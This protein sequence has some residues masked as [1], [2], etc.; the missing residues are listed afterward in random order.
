MPRFADMAARLG[1]DTVRLPRFSIAWMMAIVVVVAIDFAVC[2]AL[3][4][5]R[6]ESAE[7]I[8]FCAMPMASLLMLGLPSIALACVRRGKIHPFLVGFEL[9]GWLLVVLCGVCAVLFRES[10][11]YDIEIAISWFPLG[12]NFNF[13]GGWLA[14]AYVV[15]VT[16]VPQLVLSLVAG[17]LCQR[18][19]IRI[20]IRRRQ[21][22]GRETSE[23]SLD[24]EFTGAR[25]LGSPVIERGVRA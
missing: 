5:M 21:R 10:F 24:G 1:R 18:F 4:E 6:S 7:L 2:A 22:T 13:W 14:F 17:C 16:L 20:L 12:A 23:S 3:S 11:V 25:Q 19:E 9:M 15:F 8:L